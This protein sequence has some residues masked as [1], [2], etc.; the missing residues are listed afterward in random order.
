MIG[1]GGRGGAVAAAING[2]TSS[3]ISVFISGGFGL[4]STNSCSAREVS[5]SDSVVAAESAVELF[6]G[7]QKTGGAS[8]MVSKSGT[9]NIAGFDEVDLT[10]CVAAGTAAAGIGDC[11]CFCT[12][13]KLG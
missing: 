11:C 13:I 5:F 2:F 4:K 9:L 3:T 12:G 1:G 8:S 10:G 6:F 7:I